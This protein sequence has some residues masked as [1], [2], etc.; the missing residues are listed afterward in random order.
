MHTKCTDTRE[1]QSKVQTTGRAPRLARFT[2][3]IPEKVPPAYVDALIAASLSSR[4]VYV[5][6][7]TLDVARRLHYGSN[8]ETLLKCTWHGQPHEESEPSVGRH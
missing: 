8:L 1:E 7:S 3:R 5:L 2:D 4:L 6:P